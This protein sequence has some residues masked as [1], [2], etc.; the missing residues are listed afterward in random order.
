VPTPSWNEWEFWLKDPESVRNLAFTIG[1]IAAIVGGIVGIVLAMMRSVAAMRQANAA[2]ETQV[3]K[4]LTDSIGFLADRD[5]LELRLGAIYALERIAQKSRT[6]RSRV[7]EILYAFIRE[8]TK[9]VA[10]DESAARQIQPD[11]QACLDVIARNRPA[12]VYLGRDSA[13]LTLANADLRSV[14]LRGAQLRKVHLA[15][16]DL[17]GADL[18]QSDLREANLIGANLGSTTLRG[19][20][21]AYADL[22]KA[23]LLGC[24]L[25]GAK[26][27]S[28]KLVGAILAEAKLAESEFFQANLESASLLNADLHDAKFNG[29]NLTNANLS[30]ANLIGT[31]FR[32]YRE[33]QGG[34]PGRSEKSYPTILLGTDFSGADRSVAKFEETSAFQKKIRPILEKRIR[35][36]LSWATARGQAWRSP[37]REPPLSG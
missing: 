33:T 2:L 21:L 1:S 23:D 9:R 34:G 28:A 26:L 8:N 5:K 7:L 30:N 16:A 6:D 11:I 12:R 32:Y 37:R 17:R 13:R 22:T 14:D 10:G 4:L 18:S 36:M 25:R 35:S 31:D 24:D 3:T 20:R 27:N 19:S 29:A 15:G